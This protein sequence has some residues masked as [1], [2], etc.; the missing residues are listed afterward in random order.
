MGCDWQQQWGDD[1]QQWLSQHSG[2]ALLTT[3]TLSGSAKALVHPQQ[4]SFSLFFST[5]PIT[6]FVC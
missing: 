4:Q 5:C 2:V 3:T 1:T 6:R